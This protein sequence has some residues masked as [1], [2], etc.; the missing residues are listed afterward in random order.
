MPR[1]IEIGLEPLAAEAFRPFGQVIGRLPS[2]PVFRAPHIESWRVDFGA[3][4]P[5]EVMFARYAHMPMEFAA[6]E[7]H[8]DVTQS[9]VPLGGSASVMVVAPPTDRRGPGAR[10]PAETVRAFYA[11]GGGGILL[12]RGTWHALTRFPARPPHADFALITGL[13][14]QREIER[15]R[16]DGTRPALTE[17]HDFATADGV[18]F[19]VVDPLGLIGGASGCRITPSA[20]A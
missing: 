1:R 10:P 3:D 5:V 15:Q 18:S 6:M 11:D 14:T 19:G 2:P 16:E 12:W 9:F 4:G 17:V 8:F 7:R 13:D 20:R